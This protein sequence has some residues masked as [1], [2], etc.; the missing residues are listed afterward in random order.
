MFYPVIAK[1][2]EFFV[3]ASLNES[4]FEEATSEIIW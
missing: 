3:T 4:L 2:K 1:A